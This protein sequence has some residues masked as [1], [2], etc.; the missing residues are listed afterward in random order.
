MTS[1][2][3]A[4]NTRPLS[5]CIVYNHFKLTDREKALFSLKGKKNTAK[6]HTIYTFLLSNMTDEQRF[7]LTAKLCQVRAYWMWAGLLV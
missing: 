6:R 4:L 3:L 7:Q 1:S 5:L 2:Y